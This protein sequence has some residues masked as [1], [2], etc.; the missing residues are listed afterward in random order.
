[1]KSYKKLYLPLLI[2]ALSACGGSSG[3]GD[4]GVTT[5]ETVVTGTA[6]KGTIANAIVKAY[7]FVDGL[8]VALSTDELQDSNITT[9]TDGSYSLTVLNYTGPIKVELSVGAD[10]TMI[11]DAPAGC[12]SAVFGESIALATVDPGF[13][14]SAISDVAEGS[15]GG[16]KVHV[17]AL[18]HLAASLI[19]SESAIA[20]EANA[21]LVQEQ[22]SIIANAFGITGS[23]TEL[24]PTK[25]ES[26]ADVSGEDNE[27][28]LRYGLIN[29]GVM[30][31]LFS[32]E[33]DGVNVLSGKLAEIATDLVANDGEFLANQDEDEGFELAIVD[34]LEGAGET[35]A[36][37][38]ELI[39]ADTTLLQ[40]EGID[41]SQLETNLDNQAIV[42]EESAGADGRVEKEI[43]APTAGDEVAKAK[44]MVSD[45]R[46]FVNLFNEDKE[47]NVIGQGED[48]LELIDDAGTMIEAEAASFLLLAEL[49][50]AISEL[51]IEYQNDT[52]TKATPITVSNYITGADS[53]SSIIFDDETTNG[54]IS[55]DINVRKGTEVVVL[56]A[57]AA[58]TD[59]GKSITITLAG[60]LESAGATLT[61]A[62][63]SMIKVNLD[64]AINRDAVEDD[65]YEGDITSGEIDLTVTLAQKATDSV[66]NPVTFEG[67]VK[68]KLLPVKYHALH[69][70]YYQGQDT[71]IVPESLTLSGGF[72]SLEGNLIKATFTGSIQDLE[73]YEAPKFKYIGA[74]VADMV[75][76]T[77]S[78]DKNTIDLTLSDEVKNLASI[79]YK[80]THG[81]TD[82]DWIYTE[83]YTAKPDQTL[84]YPYE[85]DKLISVSVVTIDGVD[86]LKITNEGGYTDSELTY[87]PVDQD[88][89]GVYDGYH[90]KGPLGDD[91]VYDVIVSHTYDAS[92]S[93]LQDI[94][95]RNRVGFINSS[96]T[97]TENFL[98]LANL[99]NQELTFELTDGSEA[100]FAP[101]DNTDLITTSGTHVFDGYQTTSV[102][103]DVATINV[104]EDQSTLSVTFGDNYDE[105]SYQA[106]GS[107]GY[108]ITFTEDADGYNYWDGS[109]VAYHQLKTITLTTTDIG[110]DQ[111]S[112]E[113]FKETVYDAGINGEQWGSI[114]YITPIDLDADGKA[115][116]YEIK[117]IQSQYTNEGS[118]D[119]NGD[120]IHYP[121]DSAVTNTEST[122]DIESYFAPKAED[123]KNAIDVLAFFTPT[124]W[125]CKDAGIHWTSC[126]SFYL[127]WD[128]IKD[129]GY[130]ELYLNNE[131]LNALTVGDNLINGIVTEPADSKSLENEDVFLDVNAALSLEVILGQYEIDLTLS[132][133]R[134]GLDEGDFDLNMS[135]KLPGETL[136]R[137]FTVSVNT[138]EEGTIK[139]KNSEGVVLVMQELDDDADNNV[140]GTILV[141]SS[142]V[143]TAEIEDRDGIIMIVYS[144]ETTEAF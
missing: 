122:F 75:T 40:P 82:L 93:A 141:G 100:M 67:V 59:E 98:D 80:L 101:Y 50:D 21:A 83:T 63:T 23:L 103:D 121:E 27:D 97:L 46:L 128:D 14:L 33:T 112:M 37:A 42:I 96:S 32:G 24:E 69:Q 136:Q 73:S 89:D 126:D 62:D 38:A 125:E 66:T 36:K 3:S 88:G 92:I 117:K 138:E 81:T 68:T 45:V 109:T 18:T 4:T 39:E 79:Q 13:T 10:T 52:L 35:A 61:I 55:F 57:E 113:V 51:A 137:S 123:V 84:E 1:M 11:C 12:G 124:Y 25:V 5:T 111:P 64:T 132:G 90:L 139:A 144:D 16:V 26:A 78:D 31:A 108:K 114:I 77:T 119:A 47:G 99:E 2:S 110:L 20:G 41:L 104:S 22:S 135:Y 115:D 49:G 28:E 76:T 102:V 105:Y 85:N 9:N 143:K 95:N 129:I 131:E 106:L 8:P 53:V 70:G 134:T 120:Y 34:V 6:I 116:E 43:E 127:G 17:S 72:S 29:A 54:G 142:A 44:A 118:P 71:Q 87:T 60:S 58:F 107:D 56:T 30:A 130:T 65:T 94:A 7:K 86:S 91:Y 133:E 19:E 74:P 15:E 140:I 48:Y